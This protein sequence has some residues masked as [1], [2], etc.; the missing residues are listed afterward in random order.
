[1]NTEKIERQWREVVERIGVDPAFSRW[2]KRTVVEAL[3]RDPIDSSSDAEVLAAVLR[4][5]CDDALADSRPAERGPSASL[6]WA[7]WSVSRGS[8]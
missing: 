4:G 2:L 7:T 1:M 3:A 6:P 8:S 5:R